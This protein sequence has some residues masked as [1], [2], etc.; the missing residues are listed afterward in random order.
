MNP[1][2]KHSWIAAL[3][4]GRYAQGRGVL[5]E[6]TITGN[7]YFCAMGVLLDLV[8]TPAQ[9]DRLTRPTSRMG[10]LDEAFGYLPA[11]ICGEIGVSN[12]QQA[13][14]AG[15]N[16]QGKTFEEIADVIERDF[17]DESRLRAAASRLANGTFW[18]TQEVVMPPSTPDWNALASG[19][20]RPYMSF[21]P[22]QALTSLDDPIWY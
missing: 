15:L 9:W 16:D 19:G 12:T 18:Q 2:L 5:R 21:Q 22:A 8:A 6:R 1:Q 10:I 11:E 3:R 4:S 17:E 13:L 20:V 14:I 7:A